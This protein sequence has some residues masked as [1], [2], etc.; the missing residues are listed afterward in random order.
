[1]QALF[2]ERS[3]D[4]ICSPVLSPL[5]PDSAAEL[6]GGLELFVSFRRKKVNA[7]PVISGSFAMIG[8]QAVYFLRQ[9]KIV[10]V[11]YRCWLF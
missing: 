1:V 5:F 9:R 7:L 4:S 6:R 8:M 11:R 3:H 2:A 10:A